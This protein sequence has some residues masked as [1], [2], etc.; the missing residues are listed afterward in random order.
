[1]T[2]INRLTSALCDY[3]WLWAQFKV[4]AEELKVE[5]MVYKLS[6]SPHKSAAEAKFI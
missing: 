6:T 2:F 4:P 1:M 3:G 5:F